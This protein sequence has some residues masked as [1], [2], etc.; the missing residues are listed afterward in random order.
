[1]GPSQISALI[2]ANVLLGVLPVL[3]DT[4]FFP[5]FFPMYGLSVMDIYLRA[6]NGC[7]IYRIFRFWS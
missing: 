2:I 3:N 7:E 4:S 6:I 5:P 1:M